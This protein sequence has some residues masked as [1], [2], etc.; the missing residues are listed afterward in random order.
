MEPNLEVNKALV[1]RYYELATSCVTGFEEVV[2]DHFVDHHFP[3][4]LPPGPEG[5]RQFFTS[6]LGSVFSNMKIEFSQLVAEG[7]TVICEF[8]LRANHTAEFAGIPAK[9]NEILCPA[10]SKFRVENGKLVEAW[11]LADIAGLLEQMKK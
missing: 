5:V 7:D 1:S 8:C 2:A 11:E 4:S 3:P 9:G 6:V 10:Y